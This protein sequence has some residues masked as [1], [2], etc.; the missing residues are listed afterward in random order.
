MVGQGDTL[1]PIA[2]PAPGE[3]FAGA[4]GVD[5]GQ[6][7]ILMIY[8][9]LLLIAMY[10][11]VR[12]FARFSQRGGFFVGKGIHSRF[13]PGK[14]IMLVD[15]LAIDKEKSIMLFDCDDKRFLVGVSADKITLLKETD[16]PEI[17]MEE[18]SVDPSPPSFGE[19]FNLFKNRGEKKV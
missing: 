10:F 14:H 18:A 5:M 8:L 1:A 6:I 11:G 15:K 2:S 4:Q 16:A 9:V 12:F 7:F 13:A 17:Q 19:M 3:A